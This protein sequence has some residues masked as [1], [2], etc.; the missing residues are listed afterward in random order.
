MKNNDRGGAH[1]GSGTGRLWLVL[2]CCIAF[3]VGGVIYAVFLGVAA[4]GGRGGALAVAITFAMLFLDRRTSKDYLEMPL[5]ADTAEKDI[6]TDDKAL[7]AHLAGLATNQNQ[8]RNAFAAM[9]DWGNRQKWPLAISSVIGTVF[10]GF[11][12]IIAGCFGAV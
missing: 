9:L 1:H 4:D 5:P 8:T 10:W 6:P 3:S 11:G 7:K 12:D 2:I